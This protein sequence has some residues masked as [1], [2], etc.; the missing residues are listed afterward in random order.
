LHCEVF[1]AVQHV[2]MAAGI[3]IFIKSPFQLITLREALIFVLIA[4]VIVPFGTAFWGAAFTVSNHFGTRYWIEW[5]NL[6]ISNG[7]TA[8]V[9][10]PAILL[11]VNRLTTNGLRVA[12]G[13]I[14]E[15]GLL[16]AS[17]V[18]VGY[19]AFNRLPSGPDTSPALLYAPIPLLVWA[20]LRFGLGGVSAS[21]LIITVQ[22]IWGIMRGRGPFLAQIPPDNALD[23]QTFLLMAATP[24]MLLSVAIGDEKRSKEALR[25][26]EE[27]MSLAA[28]SA[29]LALWEWDVSRNEIWMAKEGRK[30]IGCEPGERLD[31]ATL[32]G[33]VHPDDRAARTAAIEP[34][35]GTNGSYEVEY[36]LVL[37]DG[38]VRWFAARG[39]SPHVTNGQPLQIRGVSIDITRQKQADAEAQRRREEVTHLSRVAALGMLT[40]TL[41]HELSQPIGAILHNAEAAEL[42]LQS[43]APDID[44]L[45]AIIHD[46]RKDDQR[47]SNVIHG[48]RA[49][50][51]RGEFKP[52]PVALDELMREVVT[53]AR[54]DGARRHVAITVEPSPDL[55]LVHGDRIHL[56]Q[57]LLNLL[58]NGMD[59]VESKSGVKGTLTLRAQRSGDGFVEVALSDNGP[60]IPAEQLVRM[61]EPFFTTK[62][63]G[64]GLGLSVS[65]TLIEAHGGR[66][67]AENNADG[68]AT[69]RFTLKTAEQPRKT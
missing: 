16:G 44:E 64:L 17:I 49:L 10:I 56:Q 18:I 68:G 21:M 38:S 59:A 32:A 8:I 65:R 22:A 35:L 46:I 24:L 9:L 53:L 50:L 69:F 19:F 66:I 20:A 14:L 43:G 31:F 40:G 26:S 60:G 27:R 67:W 7:V 42:F 36:R 3:R 51:K 29:Q 58:I 47:A 28:E 1:D 25:I 61:F 52:C 13:R 54:A 48:L 4:V 33:R 55:P 63:N 34:V 2:S 37:P 5:R 41:A 11:G 57:V 30:L 15:G 12:P 6:G 45:R 62:A 39:H 23:F